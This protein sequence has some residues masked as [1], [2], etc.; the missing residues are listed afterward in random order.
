MSEL[1]TFVAR[2][3]DGLVLAETWDIG[4]SGGTMTGHKSEAKSILTRLNNA[5]SRCSIDASD[6]TFQ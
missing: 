6:V 4:D 3:S 2:A 1:L 5:P